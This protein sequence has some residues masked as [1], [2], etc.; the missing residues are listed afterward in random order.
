MWFTGYLIFVLFLDRKNMDNMVEFKKMVVGKTITNLYFT[1]QKGPYDYC[2]G[3]TPA[4]YF[5]TIMELENDKKYRF[6]HNLIID[7]TE[8][9][10]EPLITLTHENWGLPISVI[11][12]EQKIASLSQDKFDNMIFYLENGVT[13]TRGENYG[14]QLLIENTTIKNLE[15]IK[16]RCLSESTNS[17]SNSKQTW[18][19]K[20]FG[21][22]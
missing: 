20:L 1:D 3:I 11:F 17:L 8:S 15:M 2:P 14:D 22:K 6:H 12:K 9:D 19:Q 10:S 4:Y 21:L 5:F 16:G 18:W 13:I 7:W